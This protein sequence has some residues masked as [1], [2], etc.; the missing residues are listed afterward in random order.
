MICPL[1]TYSDFLFRKFI[2]SFVS[3]KKTIRVLHLVSATNMPFNLPL[4]AKHTKRPSPLLLL[5]LPMVEFLNCA[6]CSSMELGKCDDV[7][8]GTCSGYYDTSMDSRVD[9]SLLS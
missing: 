2:Q 4:R 5:T 3:N 9:T 1:A 7:V 8:R 6:L